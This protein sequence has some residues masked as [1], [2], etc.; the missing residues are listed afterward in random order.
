MRQVLSIV[1]PLLLPTLLYFGYMTVTRRRAQAAGQARAFKDVPW[2]WLA[3]AGVVLVA[4]T[5][6]AMALFGGAEPGSRYQLPS[7][8]GGQVKPGGFS[9]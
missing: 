1:V 9:N 5:L 7:L 6:A 3:V 4:V 8:E 2:T